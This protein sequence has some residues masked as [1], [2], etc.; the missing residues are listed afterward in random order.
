MVA[1]RAHIG[2]LGQKSARELMLQAQVP[3]VDYRRLKF[4]AVVEADDLQ[5]QRKDVRG[6]HRKCDRKRIVDGSAAS[7]LEAV[8]IAE[9]TRW[10]RQWSNLRAER[11]QVDDTVV[12]QAGHTRVIE[13]AKAAA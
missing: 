11:C 5:R 6:R 3:F 9:R 7:G 12:R 13:H 2:E 1:M 4:R 10:R 8:G